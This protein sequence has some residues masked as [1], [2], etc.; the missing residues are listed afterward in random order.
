[1]SVGIRDAHRTISLVKLDCALVPE[2]IGD[3]GAALLLVFPSYGSAAVWRDSSFAVRGI[4][5]L[6]F[7]LASICAP[8]VCDSVLCVI[9]NLHTAGP[10]FID[11]DQ[12]SFSIVGI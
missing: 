10:R 3:L 8:I 2:R 5:I 1:M 6:K 12:R 7:L 11:L 4:V 9:E